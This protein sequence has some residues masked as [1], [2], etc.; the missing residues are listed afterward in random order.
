MP[1]RVAIIADRV[2]W[3][4]RR[5]IDAAPHSGLSIDW[6]NDESLCLGHPDGP[7]VADYE[8][9]LVRSRSYTRGGL[10]ATLAE[11][12][13]VPVLNTARA[14][15][16]CENKAVLR[17]VL[18]AAGVPVPDFRLVLS[19]KD[20]TRALEEMDVPLVLKPVYGGMGKRVTLI[21][22]TDTAQS[23]YDYVEDLGHAFEQACLVEPYLDGGASVRCLVVGRELVGA[24]EFESGGTD[25]RNNAALGNNSRAVAHDPDVLKIVDTVVAELG[26][27]IY[28]IDLFRTPDGYAVNEVNHAPGFRAV[29]STTEADIPSAIGRHVQEMLS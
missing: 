20:F 2:G 16:A 6:V 9:L 19:R 22:H 15:N 26:A 7:S 4:E 8:A 23:V 11:A 12:A 3:E 28:G 27:G 24:A 29:A 1:R 13:G 21:R 17:T 14:I 25:W 5:L 10:I 18:R